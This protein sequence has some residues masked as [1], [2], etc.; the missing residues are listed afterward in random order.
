MGQ[1]EPVVID[2]PHHLEHVGVNLLDERHI[3]RAG[4]LVLPDR[5]RC[6]EHFHQIRHNAL[7]RILD[8]SADD[9]GPALNLVAKRAIQVIA[10]IG[11]AI[12]GNLGA[13][14]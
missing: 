5:T 13:E 7:D 14:V 2:V 6:G 11:L 9:L 1:L 12:A 4:W 3:F 10:E 8:F